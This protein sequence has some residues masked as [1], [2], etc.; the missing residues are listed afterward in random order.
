M[1]ADALSRKP[2]GMLVA[3]AVEG[4][5]RSVVIGDYNLQLYKDENMACVYNMVAISI[6][7]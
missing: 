7:F 5:K 2:H 3:L 1:V 4:W 6:L